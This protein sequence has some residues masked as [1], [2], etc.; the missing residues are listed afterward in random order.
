MDIS[1]EVPLGENVGK[2]ERISPLLTQFVGQLEQYVG[3]GLLNASSIHEVRIAVGQIMYD[4]LLEPYWQLNGVEEEVQD[5]FSGYGPQAGAHTDNSTNLQR[6]PDSDREQ[7][8]G[9]WRSFFH[10]PFDYNKQSEDRLY[11]V[12]ATS[13]DPN[14]YRPARSD[15]LEDRAIG[16]DPNYDDRPQG[17]RIGESL[18]HN[19]R[20]AVRDQVIQLA[21]TAK[22]L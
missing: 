8:M 14:E 18:F 9:I 22:S 4:S 21:S 7:F 5:E 19:P 12:F 1:K 20:V 16:F 10:N 3:E 17:R 13:C 6:W 15:Y 11:R 2:N